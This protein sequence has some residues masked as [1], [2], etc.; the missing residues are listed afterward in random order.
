[1]PPTK[2]ERQTPAPKLDQPPVVPPKPSKFEALKLPD[3]VRSVLESMSH[4]SEPSGERLQEDMPVS[5]RRENIDEI[6][7]RLK[8][9][10]TVSIDGRKNESSNGGGTYTAPADLDQPT[11]H[12]ATN[13]PRPDL[14]TTFHHLL[15]QIDS[16]PLPT[17]LAF[18]ASP[19]SPPSSRASKI[20]L[21]PPPPPM[22]PAARKAVE[23]L[24]EATKRVAEEGGGVT[25]M[26]AKIVLEKMA[27]STAGSHSTHSHHQ[28]TGDDESGTQVLRRQLG[29]ASAGTRRRVVAAK[30]LKTWEK[31]GA[32]VGCE[33]PV[34][35]D[36]YLDLLTYLHNRQTRTAAIKTQLSGLYPPGSP[37]YEKEWNRYLGRERAALRKR[38]CRDRPGGF[39][40]VAQ[41]GQGGYG[42]VYLA[43]KRDTGEVVALKKMSKKLL[44]RLGEVDHILT[45]R[46][47]LTQSRASPWLVHLV[48]S[49]QD[50]EHV[51]LAMEYVA[52]GDVRTLLNTSGILNEESVRF[53]M[54]EMFLAVNDLHKMGYI[55][56]DLKPENFL[57]TS[58]G[59][60]KLTD[61]GLARGSLATHRLESMRVQLDAA[62]FNP[63]SLVYR[64]LRDR[65]T[66][67]QRRRAGP[68]EW[69]AAQSL[70]G[71]PDYMAPEIL[72]NK[73]EGYGY[74]VDYWALGCMMY[75][76]LT[77]FPPFSGASM[78]EVW[79]NVL[80]WQ[81]VLE[82]PVWTGLEA[83]YNISDHAWDLIKNLLTTKDKRICTLDQVQSHPFFSSYTFPHPSDSNT[84][85]PCSFDLFGTPQGPAP[86]YVPELVSET[87]TSHFD[88]F[89][90]P[91]DM[92]MYQEVSKR[93]E[94]MEVEAEQAGGDERWRRRGAFLGF[95]YSR[96]QGKAVGDVVR[97]GTREVGA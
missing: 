10:M 90:D 33:L 89:E 6:H 7:V 68:G 19:P 21:K 25:E 43:K 58:A 47:I 78:E 88:D 69:G 97:D 14:S 81:R 1:M 52:G 49:F 61:F 37:E 13:A 65:Q 50:G 48:S 92:A 82:R 56:R 5:D 4:K 57:L 75:E 29:G 95:T 70:V 9:E 15:S 24:K 36:H 71:S 73:G 55:H 34:F 40:M 54:A 62:H 20:P 51:Y 8:S 67:T 17:P 53:Y 12:S 76:F 31:R 28:H 74:E 11:K 59:H 27:A 84:R 42:Q 63:S 45:E 64:S 83:A 26:A 35:Y 96:R 39:E 85:V 87:D 18:R 46:D 41:V 91:G 93:R 72:R 2:T 79:N 3:H 80:H 66:L 16:I 94:E 23:E 86:P 32:M 60:I 77:G 30:V 22:S 44:H 38:R